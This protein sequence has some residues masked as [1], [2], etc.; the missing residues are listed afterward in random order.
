MTHALAL[1]QR[2]EML[3]DVLA[4]DL[5][6]GGAGELDR[7]GQDGIGLRPTTGW[8]GAVVGRGCDCR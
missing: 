5:E 2:A 3:A 1:G 6:G 4:T 8:S 7:R